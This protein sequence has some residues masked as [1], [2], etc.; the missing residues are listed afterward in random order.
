MLPGQRPASVAPPAFSLH[1]LFPGIPLAFFN[2]LLNFQVPYLARLK[3]DTE[4]LRMLI[5]VCARENVLVECDHAQLSLTSLTTKQIDVLWTRFYGTRRATLLS[6]TGFVNSGEVVKADPLQRV[7]SGPLS[8]T[9]SVPLSR[10]GSVPMDPTDLD[11]LETRYMV[12]QSRSFLPSTAPLYNVYKKL[13]LAAKRTRGFLERLWAYHV[14]RRILGIVPA[15]SNDELRVQLLVKYSKLHYPVSRV[16]DWHSSKLPGQP[17][18]LLRRAGAS[19]GFLFHEFFSHSWYWEMVELLKKLVITSVLRFVSPGST[20]QV[21]VGLIIVYGFQ[22]L[23]AHINPFVNKGAQLIGYTAFLNLFAFFLLALVLKTDTALIITSSFQDEEA[24]NAIASALIFLIFICPAFLTIYQF[25]SSVRA[26]LEDDGGVS[27][28]LAGE[29]EAER[30][31]AESD[32]LPCTSWAQIFGSRED[33]LKAEAAA[34][35]KRAEVLEAEMDALLQS[36]DADGTGELDIDEF[37]TLLMQLDITDEEEQERLFALADSD[38][39]GSLDKEEFSSWWLSRL[40][41]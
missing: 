4:E 11:L 13:R 41:H 7:N 15:T 19:C 18:V 34:R 40:Q 3:N 26:E 5:D 1:L 36:V 25:V 16:L 35:A 31:V 24:K 14:G 17:E 28:K 6:R 10:T 37:K 21:F 8:R 32:S 33:A 9:G 22:Q 39:S 38:G 12:S 20:V 2:A 29:N 23:Y 30:A 27:D